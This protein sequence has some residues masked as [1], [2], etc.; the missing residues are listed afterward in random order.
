MKTSLLIPIVSLLLI[1]CQPE[2]V[3]QE[4]ATTEVAQRNSVKSINAV[5]F[6]NLSS[7]ENA[8]IVDVRTPEE[9]TQGKIPN[10]L[11]INIYDADFESRIKELSKDQ[12][13]FIYCSAGVRSE[14]AAEFLISQ[15]YTDVYHLEG[16]LGDWYRNGFPL[17]K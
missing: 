17:E 2:K 4:S 9:V 16:G 5:D 15:G 12:S 7:K 1:S 3:S 6:Q 13:I 10:A 8:T 14:K 11:V